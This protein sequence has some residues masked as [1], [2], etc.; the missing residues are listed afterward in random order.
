MFNTQAMQ[1]F[2]KSFFG[3]NAMSSPFELRFKI[4]EMAK[5]YLDNSYQLQ[6]DLAQKN[7]ELM[8]E[9]GKLT[10]E[11]YKKM[12]P[13]NY[14]MQD[15]IAKAQELYGLVESKDGKKTK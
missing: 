3:A 6:Y 1:D 5:E 9:Q 11:T 2:Q 8:Q 7:L 13:E 10:I 14:T 12:M 15:V 4:L